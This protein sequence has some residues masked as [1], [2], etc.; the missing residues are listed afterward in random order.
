MQ[1]FTLRRAYNVVYGRV[2]SEVQIHSWE[3]DSMTV[4]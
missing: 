2:V 4:W 3:Y 1:Y